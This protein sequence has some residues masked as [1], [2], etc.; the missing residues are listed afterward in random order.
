M[1]IE[2]VIDLG[3]GDSGKGVTVDFLASRAKQKNLSTLVTRFSGGHQAGHSVYID[4][5]SRSGQPKQRVLHT[6]S[7]YAAGAFR[8]AASYFSKE[9]V[10]FPPAILA[11][12][13]HLLSIRKNYPSIAVNADL[14]LHPLALVTTP[15]DIAWNRVTEQ[16]QQHGSCGV[17]ITATVKRSEA[18]LPLFAKD[19]SSKWL[20]REKLTSIESYYRE[21]SSDYKTHFQEGD[22]SSLQSKKS[23]KDLS[24]KQ[25][26][27]SKY[28]RK[29]FLKEIEDISIPEFTEICLH[30]FG[31]IKIAPS[32]EILPGFRHL[33][34]EGSQGIL[35][36]REHGIYPHVTYAHTSSKNA[37][38][39]IEGLQRSKKISSDSVIDLY[40][41][42]R[43]YLTRHG[44]GPF[45]G[46]QKLRLNN[47]EH[48]TNR[49][50][51]YQGQL[52]IAP[53][54]AEL[55]NYALVSDAAYHEQSSFPIRK[56]LVITCLD[57]LPDFQLEDLLKKINV[58]FHR[59]FTSSSPVSENV[60][61]IIQV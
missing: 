10:I 57:Q 53:L 38:E 48:E 47:T 16:Q 18:G 45:P 24:D 27:P 55:L 3:F 15:W 50:H 35:L 14:F 19:L 22:A 39:I 8:S 34:F 46:G 59:I 4:S 17:G 36:D 23:E 49:S 30:C 2:I 32:T 61:E 21:L 6:F 28:F 51:P 44:A 52:R 60:K 33:I 13:E 41:V 5:A 37:L 12:R 42:S 11:E 9:T 7:N 54:N 25:Q 58:N 26:S 43:A 20:L 31:L 1:K 29:D 56:N 40:Y